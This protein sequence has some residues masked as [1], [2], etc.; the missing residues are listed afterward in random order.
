MKG[1]NTYCIEPLPPI[2]I[3]TSKGIILHG[4]VNILSS[5][6]VLSKVIYLKYSNR[7]HQVKFNITQV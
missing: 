1:W 7:G 2:F 5:S 4:A 6:T 3:L